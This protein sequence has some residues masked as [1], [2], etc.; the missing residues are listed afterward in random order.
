M[1]CVWLYVFVCVAKQWNV[2]SSGP[3][4]LHKY[5]NT[6]LYITFQYYPQFYLLLFFSNSN[7]IRIVPRFLPTLGGAKLRRSNGDDDGRPPKQ[8]R[9]ARSDV[10]VASLAPSAPT[11]SETSSGRGAG[12]KPRGRGRGGRAKTKTQELESKLEEGDNEDGKF[13]MAKVS[14]SRNSRTA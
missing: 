8:P 14:S 10:S 7:V 13:I 3:A 6:C 11:G 1:V 2:N 4:Q 9:V 12:N 5:F